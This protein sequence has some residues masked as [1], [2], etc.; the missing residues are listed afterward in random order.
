MNVELA[1]KVLA[2]IEAHPE[3]LNMSDW[4]ARDDVCGTTLCIAGHAMI[5]SGEYT[6]IDHPVYGVD[7]APVDG[8][9][10]TG[11]EDEGRRLLGISDEDAQ[12]L[13]YDVDNEDA[14][15]MLRNLIDAAKKEQQ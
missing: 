12:V 3:T 8:R 9:R 10:W 6:L 7:I 11:Y 15:A 4:A 14:V 1:E 5:E 13:F 2:K